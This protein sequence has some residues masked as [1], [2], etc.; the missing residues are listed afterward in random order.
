MLYL[1][2]PVDAGFSYSE[3]VD[4]VL[5]LTTQTPI[6]G[7]QSASGFTPN[8][9]HIPGRL[10][11]QDPTLTPNTTDTNVRT[12]W[13]AVQLWLKEFPNHNATDKISAWTN[14]VVTS[15]F[16]YRM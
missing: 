5:D 10:P 16:E 6:A 2:T 7:L 15:N 9:T 4:G 3:I 11:A 8:T 14:S 1:D 12:L 13:N